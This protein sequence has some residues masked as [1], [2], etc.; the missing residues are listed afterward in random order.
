MKRP[1]Q[2]YYECVSINLTKNYLK[3]VLH[4]SFRI[5]PLNKLIL[6]WLKCFNT[7]IKFVMLVYMYPYNGILPIL[8]RHEVGK[9]KSQSNFP[10]TPS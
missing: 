10:K 8:T 4:G 5:N 3:S 9:T 7:I 2:F 1:D 6:I